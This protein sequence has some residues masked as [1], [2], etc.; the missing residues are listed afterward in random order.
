M[1]GVESTGRYRVSR[2]RRKHAVVVI[3]VG[4]QKMRIA[5][6]WHVGRL[7]LRDAD[8]YSYSMTCRVELRQHPIKHSRNH[9]YQNLVEHV[10]YCGSRFTIR[11]EYGIF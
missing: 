2:R 6:A 11:N 3:R 5:M 7:Y 10:G 1:S 8:S 4:S 9:N